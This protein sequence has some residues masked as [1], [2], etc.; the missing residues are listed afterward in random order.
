MATAKKDAPTPV[1][2]ATEPHI[3]INTGYN[4]GIAIPCSV[5][6]VILPVLRVLAREYLGGEGPQ[7]AYKERPTDSLS[8]IMLD[9]ETVDAARVALKL[10]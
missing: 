1:A 8:I 6:S 2:P 9:P 3:F 7:Y 10:S 5:A 4:D